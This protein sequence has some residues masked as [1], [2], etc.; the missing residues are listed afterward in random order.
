MRSILRGTLSLT[1]YVVA[2][3]LAA[4]ALSAVLGPW[5]LDRVEAV[6]GSRLVFDTALRAYI[7]IAGAAWLLGFTVAVLARPTQ[8]AVLAWL[9]VA[10]AGVSIAFV[11]VTDLHHPLETEYS[12]I[13]YTT[14]ACLLAAA[15][16]SWRVSR[17]EH[18]TDPGQ[19]LLAVVWTVM[20]C[21]LTFLAADELFQI[22]EETGLVIAR[23]AHL[24]HAFLDYITIGY[25]VVGLAVALW[26]G[27]KILP[28]Y[29]REHPAVLRLF[30]WA[31]RCSCS[32]RC[33]TRPTGGSCRG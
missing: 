16:L 22:H 6:T 4:L 19:P 27:P 1:L 10:A 2:G 11:C 28:R 3:L 29:V 33:S 31:R 17:H 25:A 26:V 18:R 7:L 15:A 30:G 24:P 8:A 13:R 23:V 9:W 20:A 12:W 21:A 5:V 14:A 32:L